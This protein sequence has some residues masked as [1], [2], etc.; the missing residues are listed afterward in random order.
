MPP[1]LWPS[2]P[3]AVRHLHDRTVAW[4]QLVPISPAEQAY[5]EREGAPALDD[6]LER[7]QVDVFDLQRESSL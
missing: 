4:L 7:E 6:L 5:A 1:F 3:F 2:D